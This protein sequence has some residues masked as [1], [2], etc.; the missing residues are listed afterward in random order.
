[1]GDNVNDD[2]V[3]DLDLNLEPIVDP[4][5]VVVPLV[6]SF[7]YAPWLNE[8]KTTHG[9]IEDQIRQLEAVTAKARARKRWRQTRNNSENSYMGGNGNED[10]NANAVVYVED[11]TMNRER[12]RS[13]KRDI[14]QLVKALDM[15]LELSKMDEG[16]GK[17]D[18][19]R[20]SLILSYVDS[21]AKE[22]PVCKGEVTDSSIMPIYGNGKNQPV[23][24]LESGVKIPPRP[25][26]RRV[27]SIRQ[28]SVVRGISHIR[29]LV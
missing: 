12:G 9:R 24:K 6:T 7:A 23:S 27:E 5:P 22:C 14:S 2:M 3:T 20:G 16:G 19:S 29:R 18:E 10:G 11:G 4:T 28:Q 21:S 13:S 17:A 15:D 1:M 8:L 26:A 25:R